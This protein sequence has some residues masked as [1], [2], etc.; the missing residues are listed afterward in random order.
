MAVGK[1]FALGT[2][3]LGYVY[4]ALDK[5]VS[6]ALLPK[7][8]GIDARCRDKI[9]AL[10]LFLIDQTINKSLDEILRFFL[11]VTHRESSQLCLKINVADSSLVTRSSNLRSPKVLCCLGTLLSLLMRKTVRCSPMVPTNDSIEN[12]PSEIVGSEGIE[13]SKAN[14]NVSSLASPSQSHDLASWHARLAAPLAFIVPS[15]QLDISFLDN[16]LTPIGFID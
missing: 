5:Y 8:V 16:P 11:S 7:A 14:L 12:D 9:Q 13:Y 2:I 4:G 6:V 1:R 15:I 3:L 10:S